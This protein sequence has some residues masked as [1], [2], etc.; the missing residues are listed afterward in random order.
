MPT[1]SRAA[2]A[3]CRSDRGK[4]RSIT[5][6]VTEP[7]GENIV[8]RA[9]STDQIELLKDQPDLAARHCQFAPIERLHRV[10]AEMDLAVIRLRQAGQTAKQCRLAGAASAE[11]GDN[12]AGLNREGDIREHDLR[13]EALAQ[14]DNPDGRASH[15]KRRRSQALN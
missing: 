2:S 11:N 4:W 14:A 8:E 9:Q 10:L 6:Q 5:R 12:F 13:A 3:N 7:A 15:T 1:R